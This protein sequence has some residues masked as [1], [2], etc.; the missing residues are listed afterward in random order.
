MVKEYWE[1]FVSFA[2][3]GVLTFGGG[4]AMLPILKTE[5]VDNK[6]WVD[7]AELMDYY[8]LSQ[9]TPGIIAANTANF[10]GQKRKGAAGGIA[11]ALGV[12]F[13]SFVIITIIA[14]FIQ[15]FADL[16]VVNNAFA[17]IR[18]CVCVLVANAIFKLLKSAVVD[19]WTLLIYLA[20]AAGSIFT[21]LS[22]VIYVVLAGLAG[23]LVQTIKGAKKA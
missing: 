22:P 16:P 7:E 1:M 23:I 11:A 8:A 13:P 12:V 6:K 20:V 4:Y 14:A 9:C 21:D 2:K 3:V 18:V 5:V 19:V 17:G 10:I 15:N